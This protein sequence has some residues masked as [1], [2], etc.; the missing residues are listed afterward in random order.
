MKSQT[1]YSSLCGNMDSV[2]KVLLLYKCFLP[3]IQ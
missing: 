3:D 2:V 1:S